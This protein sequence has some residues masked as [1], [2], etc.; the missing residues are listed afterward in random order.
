MA[1]AKPAKAS[2]YAARLDEEL[3]DLVNLQVE[4]P[5]FQLLLTTPITMARAQFEAAQMRLY[6]MNRRECWGFVQGKAPFAVK[7]VIWKHEEDEL[8]SDA[9]AGIDHVELATREA[10]ALGMDR[11]VLESAVPIPGVQAALYAW[12]YIA[13]NAPWI[14]A[15]ASSHFLERR[16]NSSIV[17]GGGMSERWRR[18][19]VDE[20]SI[21][22][23]LLINANV[24]VEADMGHSDFIWDCIAEYVVDQRS[25][26][27][28]L[29]GAKECAVIDRAFRAAIAYAMRDIDD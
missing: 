27:D 17:R 26:E 11:E 24:H 28:A 15:L 4:T 23:S 10:E 9:R 21:D 7:K 3:N 22:S 2:S 18:K 16:N 25:Y 12:R 1:E 19:L 13:E 14:G 20:L 8:I 6:V 5:E 29:R